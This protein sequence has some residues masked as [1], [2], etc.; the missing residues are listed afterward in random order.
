MSRIT[1]ACSCKSC[2]SERQ[3][4]G[5]GVELVC[6]I[7]VRVSKLNARKHQNLTSLRASSPIWESE[8][9]LARTHILA[10]PVSLAQTGELARRLKFNH[11]L[12]LI[13][14]QTTPG[15]RC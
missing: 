3:K 15:P 12:A 5:V 2:L 6:R 4:I 13:S 7:F 8:V 9:S 11:R 10:R 14:L 1:I